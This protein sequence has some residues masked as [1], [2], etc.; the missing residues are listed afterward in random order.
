MRPDS[1]LIMLFSKWI[2]ESNKN[3]FMCLLSL[4]LF[5]LKQSERRTISNTGSLFADSDISWTDVNM[6]YI[7]SFIIV[8]YCA[9]LCNLICLTHLSLL[10]RC[11][12]TCSFAEWKFQVSMPAVC[13]VVPYRIS[14]LLFHAN[15]PL[16]NSGN[17]FLLRVT[18][19]PDQV[20][21]SY[22]FCTEEENRSSSRDYADIW[23]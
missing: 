5:S 7:N 18:E 16:T 17:Y 8:Y 19:Q 13:S 14:L 11:S 10:P 6:S 22:R 2:F 1:F 23:L 21:I 15:R 20:I 4:R 12:F 3:I 9:V